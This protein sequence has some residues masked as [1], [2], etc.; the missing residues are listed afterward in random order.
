MSGKKTKIFIDGSEGTTGLRIHE[1]FAERADVELLPIDPA[2]RKDVKARAALLNACDVAFLCLPDEAARE[3][4]SLIENPDVRVLDTSTAHRT[5]EGWAYGFPEL[6]K[7]HRDAVK[8]GKRVAVPGCH[9]SGFIALVYPLIA[10]GLLSKDA[11]LS[12]F[13]ITGYS[14]GGKKMIAEYQSEERDA[15]LFAPRIY[16]LPQQHKHL[17][18]MRHVCA[19]SVT[20]VFSPIVADY[21]SGMLVTVPLHAGLLQGA[22]DITSVQ[23]V[24]KAHYAHERFVRVTDV[25]SGAM[26]SSNALSGLD[27][28]EISVC[29]NDE[30]ITVSACFD[31]LGKG[32][33]GAAVQCLNCMLGLDEATGLALT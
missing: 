13:S 16:A 30:R 18:E 32:A 20:P 14:G 23:E 7:A 17:K 27:F 24:Y 25:Q 21:Y 2:L 11:A 29:G 31:N 33:S 1:R 8:R 12:C 4:V 10:A 15:A 3:S 28:M 19:L 5:A 22:A 9:A 6:S 26:L